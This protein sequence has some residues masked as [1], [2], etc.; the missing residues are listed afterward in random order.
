MCLDSWKLYISM[1]WCRKRWDIPEAVVN[2]DTMTR[3]APVCGSKRVSWTATLHCY[4]SWISVTLNSWYSQILSKVHDLRMADTLCV[5]WT[6]DRGLTKSRRALRTLAHDTMHNKRMLVSVVES[7]QRCTTVSPKEDDV[8]DCY[9]DDLR[10]RD[11]MRN[12]PYGAT[13]R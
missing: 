9:V 4:K 6:D 5:P 8:D 10:I 2:N 12:P 3:R 1:K 7:E 13:H 11:Y